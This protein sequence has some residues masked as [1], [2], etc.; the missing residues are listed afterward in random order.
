[1]M[2][3]PRAVRMSGPLTVW[4]DGFCVEL[5]GRPARDLTP[6]RPFPARTMCSWASLA[7]TC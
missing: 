5:A 3:D 6:V 1:M 2:S 4:V 7:V